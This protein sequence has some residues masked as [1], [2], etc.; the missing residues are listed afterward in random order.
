MRIR[1][2][3]NMDVLRY[4]SVANTN[5]I[6]VDVLMCSLGSIDKI[7]SNEGAEVRRVTRKV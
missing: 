2:P 3:R 1:L 6:L 7:H 4:W 5:A